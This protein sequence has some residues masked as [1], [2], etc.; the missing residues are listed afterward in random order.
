MA[1]KTAGKK[2]AGKKAAAKKAS[3][4]KAAGKKAAGKKAAAK[5]APAKKAPGSKAAITKLYAA[6]VAQDPSKVR[7]ALSAGAD[8]N[9]QSDRY[10]YSALKIA[11]GPMGHDDV[12]VALVEAG[13]DPHQADEDGFT[14]LHYASHLGK[15]RACEALLRAGAD[16]NAVSTARSASFEGMTKGATPLKVA[17]NAA[18]KKLLAGATTV[19]L[20]TSPFAKKLDQ[21]RAQHWLALDFE[22]GEPDVAALAEFDPEGYLTTIGQTGN[23]SVFALWSTRQTK[24]PKDGAVVY[25]DSEGEPCCAVARSL[26]EFLSV[27]PY[28]TGWLYGAALG[29][30][31]AAKQALAEVAA[32]LQTEEDEHG[33]SV[34]GGKRYASWW[35]AAFGV[36]PAKDPAAIV[37]AAKAAKPSLEAWLRKKR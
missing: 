8:P 35:K 21:V 32:E 9:G 16:P 34:L 30:P 37:K 28:G 26:D 24:E 20:S 23:G 2:A 31:S 22:G 17:D 10:S 19:G 18:I 6:V 5:K 29:K 3:G 7:D 36:P 1:K 25:F 12:A 13:A 15:A 27:L 14:P 33:Q 11:V 4:K